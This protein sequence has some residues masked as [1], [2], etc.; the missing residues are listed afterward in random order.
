MRIGKNDPRCLPSN[1]S[2]RPRGALSSARLR[3]GPAARCGHRATGLRRPLA[4]PDTLRIRSS[5]TP[6]HATVASGVRLSGSRCRSPTSATFATRGHT[7]RAIRSS[8][9]SGAFAPLLAG[10]NRCRL[11]RPPVRYR[12]ESLRAA[13]AT[14]RL[15]R[16]AFHW[17]GWGM[18]R[19]EGLER[20]PARAVGRRR[21]N[22]PRSRL[23]HPCHRH[24]ASPS[25]ERSAT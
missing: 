22:P 14:R 5:S 19:A 3:P 9:A 17:R 8:H 23:G 4:R 10:T 15:A 12:A 16:V 7:R 24:A 1:E 6:V 2:H 21:A 18:S 25:L 11:R 13:T 20:R